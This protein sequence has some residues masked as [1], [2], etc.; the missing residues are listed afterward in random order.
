[1]LSSNLQQESYV[2]LAVDVHR[3]VSFILADETY[4]FLEEGLNI[5]NLFVFKVAV[6]PNNFLEFYPILIYMII[7]VPLEVI[8]LPNKPPHLT[9]IVGCIAEGRDRQILS[10]VIGSLRNYIAKLKHQLFSSVDIVGESF[11]RRMWQTIEYSKNAPSINA[12]TEKDQLAVC[13][14]L[15]ITLL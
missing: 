1:V 12:N 8:M 6:I 7:G 11:L 9:K 4:S 2:Q 15:L 14:T 13:E 10:E 5:L 3:L